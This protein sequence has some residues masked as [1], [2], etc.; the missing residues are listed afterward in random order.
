MNPMKATHEPAQEMVNHPEH[1]NDLPVEC[2]VVAECL[3][4]N[5]GSALK[6]IWRCGLKPGTDPI[7][8][9]EKAV[10][11]LQREIQRRESKP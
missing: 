6:Y 2:I 7:Q 3:N 8:D 11:Y 9:L 5:L 1:Y 4:F 10:W